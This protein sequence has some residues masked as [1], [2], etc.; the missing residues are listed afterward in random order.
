MWDRGED[1]LHVDILSDITKNVR[2]S[3]L[4]EVLVIVKVHVISMRAEQDTAFI[5]NLNDGGP[6][7]VIETIQEGRDSW[8]EAKSF[9]VMMVINEANGS[10]TSGS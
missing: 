2:S 5:V 8:G 10:L 3:I 4:H 9:N 7:N 6:L 1:I